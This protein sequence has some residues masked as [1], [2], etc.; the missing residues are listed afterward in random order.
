MKKKVIN[1]LARRLQKKYPRLYNSM[2]TKRVKKILYGLLGE[3]VFH[4]AESADKIVTTFHRVG[5]TDRIS[6]TM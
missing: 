6:A 3:N 2:G 4:R 5:S 1:N